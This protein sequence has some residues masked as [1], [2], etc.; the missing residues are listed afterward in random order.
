MRQT[1]TTPARGDFYDRILIAGSGGQGIIVLGRLLANVA[2]AHVPHITF[3]PNYGIEV[4]G[5]M[6]NCQIILASR[7]IASPVSDEFEAML[8]MDEASASNY[9]G[10]L[11]P[12]GTAI[13][14]SSLCHNTKA[15]D[16]VHLMPATAKADSLGDVRVANVV[17]LGALIARRP[18]VAPEAIVDAITQTLG[19][20][21][22]SLL[23]LNIKAFEAGMKS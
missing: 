8:V 4:R 20:K 16:G 19:K 21:N 2:L 1:E 13:V 15:G 10:C 9:L 22:P 23:K 14:N 18:L 7:E 5:G 11:A 3:F 12:G 17:M 6:S